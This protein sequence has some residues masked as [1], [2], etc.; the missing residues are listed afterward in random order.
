MLHLRFAAVKRRT[1]ST[2]RFCI[3]QFELRNHMFAKSPSRFSCASV[4]ATTNAYLISRSV[5]A[6]V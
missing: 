3:V 4:V 5:M 6:V 2:I 1:Q